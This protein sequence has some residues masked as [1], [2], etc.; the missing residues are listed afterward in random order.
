MAALPKITLEMD[1]LDELMAATKRAYDLLQE[2]RAT[3]DEIS[4]EQTRLQV[5]INQP[6]AGTDG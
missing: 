5:K 2:L 1:G 4:V 3:L 6:T